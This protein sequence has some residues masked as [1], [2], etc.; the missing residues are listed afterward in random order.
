MPIL[1]PIAC[2]S[3]PI[4]IVVVVG[5]D[6]HGAVSTTFAV[7]SLFEG[8][9]GC[10]GVRLDAC[11]HLREEETKYAL[12]IFPLQIIQVNLVAE[13]LAGDACRVMGRLAVLAAW[14]SE[15]GALPIQFVLQWV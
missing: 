8:L 3:A 12:T 9:P 6:T 2:V 14:T 4:P 5:K 1:V 10:E 11:V 7:C 15:C 13:G